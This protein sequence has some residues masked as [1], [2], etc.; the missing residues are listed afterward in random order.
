[1]TIGRQKHSIDILRERRSTAGTVY[2]FFETK[3][4]SSYNLRMIYALCRPVSRS[5][6]ARDKTGTY[7]YRRARALSLYRERRGRPPPPQSRYR[8]DDGGRRRPLD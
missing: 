7:D 6:F 3:V 8:H 1:M 5:A 2:T 4:A